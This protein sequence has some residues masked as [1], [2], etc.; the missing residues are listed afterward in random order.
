MLRS[1]QLFHAIAESA[2]ATAGTAR[3]LQVGQ[4]SLS[5]LRARASILPLPGPAPVGCAQRVRD[6]EKSQQFGFV[7]PILEKLIVL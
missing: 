5:T 2:E 6:T 7:L 1:R 4:A 3:Q